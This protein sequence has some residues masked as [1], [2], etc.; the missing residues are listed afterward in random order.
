MDNPDHIAQSDQPVNL[1]VVADTDLLRDGL[2][3]QVQNFLGQTMATPFASNG[4]FVI[5]A[6]DNMLGSSDLIGIR[7][8]ASFSRPF[9]VVERLKREA[10]AAYLGK[11][12]E[13]Q[14]RLSETERK[15][16]ELQSQNDGG[17]G[18]IL[19][20]EQEAEIE[21]FRADKLRIRKQLRDVRHSLS[22]DIDALGTRLKLINIGLVPLLLSLLVLGMALVRSRKG[23][24]A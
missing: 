20:P 8:R 3:V 10:D 15:I 14:Q 6:N 23:G 19:T 11:E 2:W 13:L 17:Q 9:E 12:R 24:R 22:E 1:I 16:T 7:A 18:L 21:A 5:N 4:D